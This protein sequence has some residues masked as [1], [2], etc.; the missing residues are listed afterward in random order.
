MLS[1][2]FEKSPL[3]K[4]IGIGYLTL[5][6]CLR[7]FNTNYMLL[8]S[9]P[10]EIF[11]LLPLCRAVDGCKGSPWNF[12]KFLSMWVY[13]LYASDNSIINNFFIILYAFD[14]K[15]SPISQKRAI[16]FS[17]LKVSSQS[18]FNEPNI[19]VCMLRTRRIFFKHRLSYAI[20]NILS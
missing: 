4:I 20:K 18:F 17:L 7:Y 6:S 15:C 10:S 2:N 16:K 11:S 19:C 9:N 3:I 8:E 12:S 1:D 14:H 13:P 5:L